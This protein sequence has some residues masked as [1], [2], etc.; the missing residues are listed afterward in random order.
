MKTLLAIAVAL[1]FSASAARAEN[2]VE[3]RSIVVNYG[4]LDLR[5]PAGRST[6]EQRVASAVNRLCPTPPSLHLLS[7]NHRQACKAAAWAGAR[8]QLAGIYAHHQY[9]GPIILELA[10]K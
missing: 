2:L 5:Q 4:D 7:Q 6:L 10:A 1:V 9:A 3:T 8:L